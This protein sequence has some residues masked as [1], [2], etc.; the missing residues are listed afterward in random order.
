MLYPNRT[1]IRWYRKCWY[2][3]AKYKKNEEYNKTRIH[4]I[5]ISFLKLQFLQTKEKFTNKDNNTNASSSNHV[6][7]IILECKPGDDYVPKRT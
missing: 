2:R 7:Y 5:L 4:I 6:H 3:N 1:Q